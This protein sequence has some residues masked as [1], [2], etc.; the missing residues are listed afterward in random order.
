MFGVHVGERSKESKED[1]IL[2][3]S[4]TDLCDR[5]LEEKDKRVFGLGKPKSRDS[6]MTLTGTV[7]VVTT[8]TVI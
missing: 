3:N 1:V 4:L 5:G 7:P 6:E 8:I 2:R